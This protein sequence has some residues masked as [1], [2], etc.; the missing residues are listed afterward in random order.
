MVLKIEGP[1]EPED[2][3]AKLTRGMRDNEGYLVA[4]RQERADIS[5]SQNLRQEQDE[6]YRES[7]R[8][9]EEKVQE[10]INGK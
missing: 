5:L 4:A 1:I 2:L 8:Q 9:D 7:L 10:T 3:V 6:A